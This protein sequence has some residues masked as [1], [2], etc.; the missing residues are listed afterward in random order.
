MGTVERLSAREIEIVRQCLS[1]AVEGPFFP[2]WEF[3][4]LIGLDRDGVAAVLAAWPARDDDTQELAVNN[5]L[6]NLLDSHTTSGKPG[7]GTSPPPPPTSQPSW[8]AG[9]ATSSST[10]QRGATLTGCADPA[11][12]RHWQV[13]PEY[14]ADSAGSADYR[15]A[16][17]GDQLGPVVMKP[18]ELGKPWS[19]LTRFPDAAR[20]RHRDPDAG[21]VAHPKAA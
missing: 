8:R 17:G 19:S 10:L 2:D 15:P 21:I 7:P 12:T 6:N 4:A 1:A 9:V 13:R 11:P 14:W 20:G 16:E 5:V 18:R 3:A